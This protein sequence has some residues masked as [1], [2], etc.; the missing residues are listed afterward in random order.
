M[1]VVSRIYRY[2]YFIGLEPVRVKTR[3]KAVTSTGVL[4]FQFGCLG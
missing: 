4:N 3:F 1:S 2:I